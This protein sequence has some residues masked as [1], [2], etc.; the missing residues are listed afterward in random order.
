M[1][2][3]LPLLARSTAALACAL[4]AS[5]VAAA[6][7]SA[8]HI[9]LFTPK[10]QEVNKMPVYKPKNLQIPPMG[11]NFVRRIHW[12]GWNT[13]RAIG[14]GTNNFGVTIHVRLVASRPRKDWKFYRACLHEQPV[15]LYTY[16]SQLR[17]TAIPPLPHGIKRGAL[18]GGNYAIAPRYDC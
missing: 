10:L 15:P 6:P 2:R 3:R 9:V 16:Y 8:A 12:R 7:A 5:G 18:V 17:I 1:S 11:T 13:A 4:G 14:Y